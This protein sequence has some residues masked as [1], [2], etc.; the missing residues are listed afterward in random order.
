MNVWRALAWVTLGI[1]FDDAISYEQR[2][3]SPKQ[4]AML[5]PKEGV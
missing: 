5:K 4:Y 1:S 2:A 3:I